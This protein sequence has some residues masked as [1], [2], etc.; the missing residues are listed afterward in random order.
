MQLLRQG[1]V[2]PA[3]RDLQERLNH[4]Q[5][6]VPLLVIDGIF[7]SKTGAAV[8]AFQLRSGLAVDGIVGPKTQAALAAAKPGPPGPGPGPTPGGMTMNYTVPGFV[9]IA[10]DKSMSCWFASAQMLIQWKERRTQSSD[11]RHPDPSQ[12]PKWSKLYS[13]DVGIT[14]GR[15]REFG[16]DMGFMHVPPMSPTPEAILLWL[17]THGPLWVNGKFHITVMAGIRG[18]RDN[19]EVLVLDPARKTETRGAWRNLREWY[20]LDKH[21]GRDSGADVEAVFLRLP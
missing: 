11:S 18:G 13:D 20:I 10:Q 2:G 16:R 21:S 19:P 4:V 17:R 1:S 8:R 5:K 6:P 12:S 9:H 7:G 14:N 15:I 3:V